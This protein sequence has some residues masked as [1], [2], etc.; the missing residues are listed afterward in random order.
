MRAPDTSHPDTA[1]LNDRGSSAGF[2]G[3]TPLGKA[4]VG[5]VEAPS[6]RI[7]VCICTYRRPELLG[8]LLEAL[9][10]QET[11]GRFTYSVVVIDNDHARSA[12]AV[13][14]RFAASSPLAVRYDVEPRQNIAR[15]RN[16]AVEHATGDFVAFIDDDECPPPRWLL[17]LFTARQRYGADGVLGPV[18]PRYAEPPPAWVVRGRFYERA[19]YPTG[20]VI[21]WRKGRTGNVLLRRDVFP[22]GAPPFRPEFLSGE[23]QD[24]FRRV[25]A[26]GRVFVWCDEAAVHEVVPPV[27]WR[28]TFM[29]KRALLRGAVSLL[30]PTFGIRDVARSLVAVAAYTVVLPVALLLGQAAFMTYLV[31]LCDHLGR[32][33]ALVGIRPIRRPYITE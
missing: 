9:A 10:A 21:D 17:T 32:L 1:R 24:F 11:G 4:S 33:L 30:H 28:R 6:E 2:A 18:R 27:R 22:A 29:V 16:R 20:F 31:K 14:R 13:V 7:T 25:I 8:P 19:T 3:A 26:Q 15:A 12:E 5:A 23:D